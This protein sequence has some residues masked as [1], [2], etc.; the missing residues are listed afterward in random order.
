MTQPAVL[1]MISGAR[2]PTISNVYVNNKSE[3]LTLQI[4]GTFSA[5]TVLVQGLVNLNSTAWTT[6]AALDLT[7]F[8]FSNASGVRGKGIYQI[9]VSGILRVRINLTAISG[10]DITVAANFVGD[11]V[12]SITASEPSANLEPISAYDMAVAGG[13]TGTKEQFET[14]IGNSAANAAAA[15]EAAARVSASAEQIAKNTS[16]IANLTDGVNAVE[17]VAT[18]GSPIEVFS[19]RKVNGGFE[20]DSALSNFNRNACY[21]RGIKLSGTDLLGNTYVCWDTTV[22]RKASKMSLYIM[23][24]TDANTYGELTIENAPTS[25][26][27]QTLTELETKTGVVLRYKWTRRN[28]N[29]SNPFFSLRFCAVFSDANNIEIC[30]MYSAQQTCRLIDN[31]LVYEYETY[32][33]YQNISHVD[34]L[35]IVSLNL[36]QFNT[37]DQSSIDHYYPTTDLDS[38]NFPTNT[39]YFSDAEVESDVL[40][41]VQR[42][43]YAPEI[44]TRYVWT[45]LFKINPATS[46]YY[47][48]TLQDS[49][50]PG[51]CY[52]S[53][54]GIQYNSTDHTSHRTRMMYTAEENASV[55]I[56]VDAADNVSSVLLNQYNEDFEYISTLTKVPADDEAIFHID[57]GTKYIKVICT[58]LTDVYNFHGIKI[59]S[60]A[61]ISACYNPNKGAVESYNSMPFNYVVC[62]NVMTSGRL[63]LP[64][65]YSVNGNKVPLIVYVHG[66]SA[67]MTWDEPMQ[68]IY[69]DY[70]RY[71]ANEGY[72]VFDCYPWTNKYVLEGSPYSPIMIPSHIRS[73]IEGIRYVCSRFNVD[74]DSTVMLCKSQGGMLAEWAIDQTNFTFKAIALFAPA[75][76]AMPNNNKWFYNAN[77]RAALIKHVDFEGTPEEFNAFVTSGVPTDT[78][79]ASFIEKNKAKIVGMMPWSWN[80]RGV[81]SYDDIITESV[82]VNDVVPQWMLDAG[83]PAMP[84]GAAHYKE[85]GHHSEYSK[86]ATCPVKFWCAFDDESTSSYNNYAIYTWLLNGGSKA[87]FRVLPLNT[88][89]H[90]AMDYSPNALKSSGTTALGIPY[91]DMPT[92]YVEAATFFRR[93]LVM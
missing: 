58:H 31:E 13:Y 54:A 77:T 4:T 7:D 42:T 20:I 44:N 12:S 57:N 49:C 48:Y 75:E 74:M 41:I 53:D 69:I 80:I 90:H 61:P 30:R 50:E 89:G 88:G 10:G 68:T 19:V 83:L 2:S 16:D 15:E 72:A 36:T 5:A 52:Q 67:M 28:F 3:R 6:L 76:D 1:T 91:T 56:T 81:Q 59:A 34:A 71:L 35:S 29:V 79:V 65:N 38:T 8:T 37:I 43:N 85:F 17:N 39:Y 47:G 93:N 21:V 40:Y 33:D 51:S 25:R 92:A 73:Y 46:N 66:S 87:E 62:G 14:D 64:P 32:V 22:K 45:I 63:L 82:T 86:H 55:K 60:D 24:D 11:T 9:G 26:V 84:Q 27:L 70:L 78:L 18:S 23:Y